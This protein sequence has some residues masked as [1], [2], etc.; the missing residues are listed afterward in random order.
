[1]RVNNSASNT[2]VELQQ[3]RF[4]VF[5]SSDSK[6]NQVKNETVTNQAKKGPFVR[7]LFT[8]LAHK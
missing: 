8:D 2:V 1:M 6:T 3:D 5:Q 4:Y 7:L